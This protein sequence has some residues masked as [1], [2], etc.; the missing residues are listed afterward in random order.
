M[1]V[2]PT[3][4]FEL[5]KQLLRLAQEQRGALRADQLQRFEV[6]LAERQEIIDTLSPAPAAAPLPANVILFPGPPAA[7]E[8]RVALE[9]LV[10]GI[11]E[12]DR[13]NAVLLRE[14]REALRA[15][16]LD[17]QRGRHALQGYQRPPAARGQ[18]ERAG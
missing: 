7:D 6:L 12:I 10:R 1:A 4:R 8:D 11:L 15:T 3:S 5:L 16:L 2:P 14:K 13:E 9:A 17:M 18:Y